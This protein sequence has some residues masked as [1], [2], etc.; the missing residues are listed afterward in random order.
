MRTQYYVRYTWGDKEDLHYQQK[1]Y[2][3][4]I[5]KICLFWFA[6]RSQQRH[7]LKSIIRPNES[8]AEFKIKTEISQLLFKYRQWNWKT[9]GWVYWGRRTEL[10]IETFNVIVKQCYLI[11]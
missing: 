1:S 4:N 5:T 3:N 10:F 11:D 9:V 2:S 8:L 6:N 7:E